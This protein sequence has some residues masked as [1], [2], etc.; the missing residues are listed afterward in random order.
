MRGEFR[1]RGLRNHKCSRG[2]TEV[3]QVSTVGRG[4][5]VVA[6]A[7]A[8][9][10]A[11]L[12]VTFAE[13]LRRSE[14]LEPPHT[15]DAA[16]DAPVILLQ[17]FV[18]VGAGPVHDPS[19]VRAAD[20]PWIGA[21]AVR[22]DAVGDNASCRFGRAEEGLGR[23]H[24]PLLAEHGV[25][26]IAAAVDRSIQVA[27]AATDLHVRLILSAKSGGLRQGSKAGH[28]CLGTRPSIKPMHHAGE[29]GRSAA[30]ASLACTWLWQ[31]TPCNP[32]G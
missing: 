24:V 8:E 20:R 26:E 15:S 23:R 4:M 16:F 2:A 14:A 31:G 19:A 18:F 30:R 21:V 7:G 1:L 10:V 22:G 29:S 27:P 25:H 6:G 11:K 3:T 17:P 5:L 12:V 28:A 32:L 13:A 9:E